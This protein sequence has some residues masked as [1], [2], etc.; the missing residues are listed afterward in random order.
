MVRSQLPPRFKNVATQHPD[1]STPVR[2][3]P[4]LLLRF[5]LSTVEAAWI[6]AL[7]QPWKKE[8]SKPMHVYVWYTAQGTPRTNGQK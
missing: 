2:L 4:C 7:T 8:H 1:P 5:N 3:K 6:T